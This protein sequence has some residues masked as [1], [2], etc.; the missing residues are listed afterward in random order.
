M[1][2][3]EGHTEDILKVAAEV[4]PGGTAINTKSEAKQAVKDK[5]KHKY[6]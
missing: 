2:T 1:Q 3:S 4:E 5:D 6:G